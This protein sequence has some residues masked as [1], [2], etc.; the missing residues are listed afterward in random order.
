VAGPRPSSS[1]AATGSTRL[2]LRLLGNLEGVI[3]LDTE[4][5]DGAFKLR[6]PQQEL[7]GSEISGP[8]ID[9]L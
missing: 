3:Y 9:Q 7:N 5:S 4:I 2:D 8:P 6:V 1:T